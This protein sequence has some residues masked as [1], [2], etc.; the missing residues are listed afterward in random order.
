MSKNGKNNGRKET[1]VLFQPSGRRGQVAAGSTVLG[2]ARALGV[3]IDSTCG[4]R[5]ICG[6][7]QVSVVSGEV[8]PPTAA[9]KKYASLR[10]LK[11]GRRLAC[12]ARC[13]GDV[14][15]D[16]PPES[17]IHRQVVRKQADERPIAVD[18]LARALLARVEEAGMDEAASDFAR[19]AR[20]V[21]EQ[22]N[23]PGLTPS[24]A[25][26]RKLQGA[27]RDGDR[28]VTAIV[29]R[30]REN[31]PPRLIDVR[32]GFDER[33]YGLAVDIGSTTLAAHLVDLHSG[34]V[35]A[36]GGMMNPQIRFGEDLMSRVSWAMTHEDGT[37]EM[38][39]AVRR[40]INQLTAEVARRAGVDSG[41]IIDAV[42]VGNPVM[43]HLFLGI[44]PGPLGQ[45]PFALATGEALELAAGELELDIAPAGRSY[46]L[47]CI[48]GHVGADAAAVIL[49]EAPFESDELTLIVDVGTNAEIVLGDSRRLL[50]CSSP[51]GPA[52]EGAE[53]SSGQRAAPGAIERVRVD[54][55]T[56]QARYKVIGVEQWSHEE[57]F[58]EAVRET[59]VT[60]ICGSGIIEAV[61]GM[62]LAGII[63]PDGRFD[64][65]LAAEGSPVERRGR[66]FAWVLRRAGAD[67][68]PEI[69]ITQEDVRA[70][71]LAKA[72]L[73][74]G[75]RLLMDEMGVDEVQRIRLA[76][77]FGNHIDPLYAM[78]L[79][80]IPD[81][82][83][84][85]V[86]SAGNAAGSGARMALVS[87]EA[88]RLV[89]QVVSR[90]EKVETA[91]EPRFQEHFVAA[92]NIPHASAPYRALEGAVKL[93]EATG[94]PSR[95]KGRRG[96]RE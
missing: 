54:P 45:A 18:P 28:E 63:G 39:K 88:R 29:H 80:M 74:A 75:A 19:L 49:A 33:L 7:C 48:A 56:L 50:A 22:W 44:D 31:A 84:E 53:I 73:Y 65:R 6:R 23:I 55:D 62:Y 4:G 35:V 78:V 2:A 87:G 93:P 76:G 61:A 43:H 77:A 57:G 14:T 92:M 41:H 38:S 71:Q 91:V 37:R 5:A 72:A 70:V 52:F 69:A 26:L 83:L 24:P 30:A 20:A 95:R 59:G 82:P 46:I 36:S 96:R 90:V 15:I 47:P 9:E 40:A 58:K 81:C 85:N 17:Q 8:S 25:A 86:S 60:G 13:L 42:F 51:T 21:E 66:G 32:P 68:G 3:D 1:G 79:G 94:K 10:G 16:V 89:E 11:D 67:G 12:Q 34:A 64:E 27:L